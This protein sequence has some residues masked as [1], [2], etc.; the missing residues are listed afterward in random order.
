MKKIILYSTAAFLLGIAA[1]KKSVDFIA[2]NTTTGTGFIPV[3]TNALIDFN[4]SPNR[5]L[6]STLGSSTPVYPG[7][8][9]LKV[10]LQYFSQ[11][12]IREIVLYETVGS[13]SRTQVATIPYAPAFSTIKR[14]DT[15]LVPYTV[16]ASAAANT[17]IKLEYEIVNQNTLKLTRTGWIRKNP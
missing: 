1:C 15:L 2:D 11:S 10:E 13:G 8:T 16:P 17:G 3:S 4:N 9:L 5:T 7:G 6:T 12:P 14:L